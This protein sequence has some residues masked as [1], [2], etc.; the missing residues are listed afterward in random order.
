MAGPNGLADCTWDSAS[1]AF[2]RW[3][4]TKITLLKFGVP[5]D[6]IK[7]EKIRP[8]GAM[9]AT[10][11]TPG[12]SE[13]GDASIEMLA[14][15]YASLVLPRMPVHAGTDVEFVVTATVTHPSVLGGYG[16]LCDG[17]RIIGSEGPD[18]D[19]TEKG[20]VK[21]LTLSVMNVWERGESGVWK[22]YARLAL[23]SSQAVPL[24]NF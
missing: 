24:L 2:F 15:D 9:R 1:C 16:V 5:K 7:V 3:G 17:C 22:T 20:L 11:R 21:K 19:G 4:S 12:T 14:S 13:V 8:I 18:F 23:P 10:R 6:D